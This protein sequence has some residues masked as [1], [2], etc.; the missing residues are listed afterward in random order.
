MTLTEF[1]STE[2]GKLLSGM[3]LQNSLKSSWMMASGAENPLITASIRNI[4]EA[5]RWQFWTGEGGGGDVRNCW[6]QF[7]GDSDA[8]T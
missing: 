5:A 6:W 2:T 7:W 8:M 1:C 3:E 4:Q